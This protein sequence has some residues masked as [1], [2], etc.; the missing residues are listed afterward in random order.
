MR[1]TTQ[2]LVIAVIMTGPAVGRPREAVD[3]RLKE[4]EAAKWH[5]SSLGGMPAVAKVF[6]PDFVTVEYGTDFNG[7]VSRK[8]ARELTRSGDLEK[9]GAALDATRFQLSEWKVLHPSPTVV[10]LSYR[11]T[12]PEL[13]WTAYATSI[14][15]TRAGK[16]KT[17]FYQA[18]RAQPVR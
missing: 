7:L 17:V 12:A 5:P 2:M 8:E 9:L 14:W 6:S 18:S 4:L 10:V 11:V 15:V 1:R 16:W 13:K 3:A